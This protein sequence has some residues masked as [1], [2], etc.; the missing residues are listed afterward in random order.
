[1]RSGMH[2]EAFYRGI[3]DEIDRNG[4]WRGEIWNRRKSGELTAQ[5]ETISA[6]RDAR[7]E[8]KH[9]IGIFSDITKMVEQQNEMKHLAHHDALTVSAN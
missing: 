3:W 1:M 6:V 5:L 9:Y 4:F 7:G 2:D 8:I